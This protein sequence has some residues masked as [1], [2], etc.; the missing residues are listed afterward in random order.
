MSIKA[1][2]CWVKILQGKFHTKTD[3]TLGHGENYSPI[4]QE[5]EGAWG[6]FEEA[7]GAGSLSS[8]ASPEY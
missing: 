7:G 4:Q 2:A 1:T 8:L 5:E 3:E 6:C